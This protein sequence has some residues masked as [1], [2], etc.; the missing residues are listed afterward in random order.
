MGKM[1]EMIIEEMETGK[2][3]NLVT[4]CL[5]I[6]M[7]FRKALKPTPNPYQKH[8]YD[9]EDTHY[10]LDGMKSTVTDSKGN[11]YSIEIKVL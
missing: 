8:L 11:K 9:F 5:D 2:R 10:T 4:H 3:S 6:M 7:R 1:K